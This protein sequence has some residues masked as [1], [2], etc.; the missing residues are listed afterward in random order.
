MTKPKEK[1][2]ELLIKKLI[3]QQIET[4]AGLSKVKRKIAKASKTS[5]SSNVDLLKTYH[6]LVEKKRIRE[7]KAIERLLITRPVRSLSGIVNISV[8]TKPYPCPGR[9]IYC[10]LEPGFPKSYLSG[11]PAAQRAKLLEFDPYLQVKT[12]LKALKDQGHPIDKIELRII[13]ATWSHY[14][15]Q[16]QTWFIKNCFLAANSFPSIKKINKKKAFQQIQKENEGAKNRIVG[17]SI[18]TRPDFINQKEIKR[19]RGLGVTLVEMGIQTVFDDIHKKCQ[20][21]LTVQKISQ[22][23]RLLK[24]AGFKVLYQIMPNLPGSNPKKDLEVFKILF[25]DERFKPD[26]LKIYPCLVCPGTKLFKIWKRGGYKPYSEKQLVSLLVKIKKGLPCWTRVARIFRDIP[27]QSIMAGIKT[28][29]LRET[30]KEEMEK[31][32]LVCLCIRCREVKA[33]YK[34]KEKPYLFRQDYRASEGREIFLTFENK[35][36]TKLFSMLR[37]RIPSCLFKSSSHSALPVLKDSALIR[38][39]QTF[40]PQI[41]ISEKGPSPQHKGLAKKLI[42]EAE[43]IAQKEFGLGKIAVI[44]GVGVR[45]YFRKSGFRLKDTYMIKKI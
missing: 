13:G 6:K 26:W 43:K 15:K 37:L 17:L 16:Y 44:S 3:D 41:P 7:S 34:P 45:T 25:Q 9:C 38:E 36:R 19:L 28:S 29:N 23:T 4:R 12:R 10:P 24:D 33:N 35:K 40:G 5:F 30:I 42:Q 2:N 18:E 20:T 32:G 27:A 8:L 1:A 31:Q 22:A 11:E 21:G 39:V 14:P